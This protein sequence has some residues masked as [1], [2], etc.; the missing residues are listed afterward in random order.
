MFANDLAERLEENVLVQRILEDGRLPV[1][2]RDKVIERAGELY[3]QGPRH[4]N[5]VMIALRVRLA[6]SATDL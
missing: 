1:P 5:P 2:P 6:C 3:S 4:L